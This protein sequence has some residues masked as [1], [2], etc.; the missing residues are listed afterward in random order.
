MKL[1]RVKET[2]QQRI[3]RTIQDVARCVPE[4][5]RQYLVYRGPMPKPREFTSDWYP[6]E[7][8]I[9]QPGKAP[10]RVEVLEDDYGFLFGRVEKRAKK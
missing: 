1:R 8:V 9:E 6:G 5:L 4:P 2:P 3:E 7:L 10:R